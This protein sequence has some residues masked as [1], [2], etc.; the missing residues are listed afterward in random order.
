MCKQF[1]SAII[2]AAVPLLSVP[3]ALA[4]GPQI[5]V[6][7]DAGKITT[8]HLLTA[9]PYNMAPAPPT[10]PVQVYVVPLGPT[11]AFGG[12]RWFTRPDPATNSGP[13]PAWGHGWTYDDRGTPGDPADDT[14]TT[15]F[16]AGARFTQTLLGG[17]QQWDGSAFAAAPGGAQLEMF[18]STGPHAVSGGAVTSINYPTIAPPAGANPDPHGS[19]SFA[20]LGDGVV[21]DATRAPAPVAD[22]IYSA[23]FQLSL[24]D[25]P[26]GS[27]VGPSEPFYFVMYKGV[28]QSQAASAAAAAYPGL[29]IQVVPEPGSLG[30]VAAGLL[31]LRRRRES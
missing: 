7:N 4:H 18:R 24:S 12:T 15:T 20:V 31:L 11:N 13:G 6:T 9:E 29:N 30:A 5:Q 21:P 26:A 2:V 17:L 3:P 10:G 16:P 28:S 27:G 8:R 25:Q 14:F 23:Q 1:A 22:G 19:A